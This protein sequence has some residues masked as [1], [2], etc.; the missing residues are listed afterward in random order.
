MDTDL[1][2]EPDLIRTVFD[3]T[4]AESRLVSALVAG[5]TLSG[6]ADDLGVSVKTV[7]NQLASAFGK[8]QTTTQSA[9]VR[10][11]VGTLSVPVSNR[12]A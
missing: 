1:A 12:T 5:R 9:L 3:L 10:L 7:R 4:A 6:H 2:I 11:V 8:T